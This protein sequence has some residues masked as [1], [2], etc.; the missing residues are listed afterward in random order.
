M[1]L[2]PPAIVAFLEELREKVE[3]KV[4]EAVAAV[5]LLSTPA[6]VPGQQDKTSEELLALYKTKPKVFIDV[7]TDLVPDVMIKAFFMKHKT[8]ALDPTIQ[9]NIL[10]LEWLD[11]AKELLTL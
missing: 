4:K 5:E 9:V 1:Y 3:Q 7:L 10:F 2:C 11:S 8:T 6:K